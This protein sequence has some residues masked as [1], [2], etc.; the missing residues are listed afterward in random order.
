MSLVN[1]VSSGRGEVHLGGWIRLNWRKG[2]RGLIRV[3]GV[4]GVGCVDN[5]SWRIKASTN[6]SLAE[7]CRERDLRILH[8]N[9]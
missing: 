4:R 6:V 1:R 5:S 9:S 2:R 3:T 7:R 8:L